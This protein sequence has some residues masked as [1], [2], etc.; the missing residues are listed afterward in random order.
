MQTIGQRLAEARRAVGL[1]RER[2]A[3]FLGLSE[4]ELARYEDALEDPGL[5]IVLKLADLYSRSPGWLLTG[6]E[7]IRIPKADVNLADIKDEDLPVIA[8]ANRIVRNLYDLD[9]ILCE[10]GC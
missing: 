3:K 2:A 1:A 10:N 5:D 7:E 4:E 8:K 6:E 9:K